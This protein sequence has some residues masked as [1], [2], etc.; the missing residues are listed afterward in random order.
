MH[1]LGASCDQLVHRLLAPL[2]PPGLG[3]GGSLGGNL[4]RRPRRLS[5]VRSPAGSAAPAPVLVLLFAAPL[6]VNLIHLGGGRCLWCQNR[7]EAHSRC[8]CARHHRSRHQLRDHLLLRAGCSS[9]LLL[10]HPDGLL[11]LK[12]LDQLLLGELKVL[13]LLLLLLRLLVLSRL[14]CRLPLKNG[15]LD[16]SLN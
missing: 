10:L 1:L 11:L 15:Q 6:A 3:L 9:L 2:A 14:G 12:L 5:P 16:R 4:P 13:S 7:H 8:G